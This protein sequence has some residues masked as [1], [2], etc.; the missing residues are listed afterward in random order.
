MIVLEIGVILSL[1]LVEELGDW[2]AR[3]WGR[4]SLAPTVAG[5]PN[6]LPSHPYP[7]ASWLLLGLQDLW[8]RMGIFSYTFT[9]SNIQIFSLLAR[10]VFQK[11][12]VYKFFFCFLLFRIAVLGKAQNPPHPSG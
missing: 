7:S 5:G 6:G 12:N 3:G 4:L 8:D 11:M 2:A 10:G 9:A 1:V